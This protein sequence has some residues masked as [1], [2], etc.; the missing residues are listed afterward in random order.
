MASL[1]I[2]EDVLINSKS[3]THTIHIEGLLSENPMANNAYLLLTQSWKF[4]N[5]F[6]AQAILE[7][8]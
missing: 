1:M 2:S 3:G 8:T 7:P 6:Q 4:L 5:G